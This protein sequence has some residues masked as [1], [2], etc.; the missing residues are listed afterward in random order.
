MYE[1]VFAV[2]KKG[3]R[4]KEEVVGS[5]PDVPSFYVEKTSCTIYERTN[6]HWGAA[7]GSRAA[8]AKSHKAK[9]QELI[10]DNR[11]P[12]FMMRA[13]KFYRT[14]WGG[15]QDKEEERERSSLEFQGRINQELHSLAPTGGGG[16]C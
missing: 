10:H 11:E 6:E 4:G 7:K 2:C 5:N 16:G 15:G 14:N 12:E 1:N 3:A 9:R 8:W 13:V